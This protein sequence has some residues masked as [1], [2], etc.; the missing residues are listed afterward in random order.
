M[1]SSGN[2]DSGDGFA[3]A[4]GTALRGYLNE[5][6]A[7]QVDIATLLGLKDKKGKPNKSRL[8]SYLGDSPPI[9]GA[10]VLY[11]ACTKLEGFRFEY[12]GFRINAELLRRKGVPQEKPAEQMAFRFNRQ[13]NLTAK[14]GTITEVGTFAVKVKRPLGRIEFSVSLKANK[15]SGRI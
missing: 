2:G 6:G 14:N 9:P 11:L 15:G 10:E 7:T 13:F 8:N 1:A 4:F 5:K 3:R 12:N